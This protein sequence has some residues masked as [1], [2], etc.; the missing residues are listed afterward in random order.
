MRLLPVKRADGGQ[1]GGRGQAVRAMV[2]RGPQPG[3]R[4]PA[5]GQGVRGGASLLLCPLQWFH[6]SAP[7]TPAAAPRPGS[8]RTEVPMH[9]IP[10][11]PVAAATTPPPQRRVA[12][13]R[14]PRRSAAGQLRV[15]SWRRR[16]APDGRRQPRGKCCGVR[17]PILLGAGLG[18]AEAGTGALTDPL[19]PN[20][21]ELNTSE[22]ASWAQ[23]GAPA[24]RRR[25][26]RPSP[27]GLA[28]QAT[29][30]ILPRPCPFVCP[31]P[32]PVPFGAPRSSQTPR[33]VSTR[34]ALPLL[35]SQPPH[36]SAT[37]TAVKALQFFGA[38]T[39]L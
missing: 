34:P 29:P 1:A 32:R 8:R 11:D 35:Q 36:P 38:R 20:V 24:W 26:A 27:A 22:E 2:R 33:A 19:S 4:R 5:D 37:S 30:F 10:T 18:L 13:G 15:G 9:C 16:P 39:L 31:S 6:Q 25:G 21:E 12:L 23:C 28:A 14:P 3:Q 7:G 17:V